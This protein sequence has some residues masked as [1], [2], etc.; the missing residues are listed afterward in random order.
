MIAELFYPRELKEVI[1][2]LRA[3]GD[4]NEEAVKQINKNAWVPIIL[5]AIIILPIYFFKGYEHPLIAVAV[6][7]LLGYIWTIRNMVNRIS[8]PY[9]LGEPVLGKIEWIIYEN[10]PPPSFG[11]HFLYSFSNSKQ[12]TVKKRFNVVL[13]PDMISPAPKEGDDIKIYVY[14]GNEKY[15]APFLPVY[16]KRFCLSKNKITTTFE[17]EE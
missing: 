8:L 11:W 12:E 6:F 13:K 5:G 15:H 14:S 2:D 9:T 4:L 17:K 1:A 16:F 10:F 3:K 7:S